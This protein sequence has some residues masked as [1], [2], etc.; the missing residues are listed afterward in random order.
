MS[1]SKEYKHISTTP[2]AYI[3]RVLTE[4]IQDVNSFSVI[5]DYVLEIKTGKTPSKSETKYFGKPGINWIKPTDIGKG[6]YL[7][8]STECVT[9]EALKDNVAT[10]Y[11]KNSLLIV[12]IGAGV[13]RVALAQSAVS[14]NQQITGILFNDLVLPEYAY[15]YFFCREDVIKSK[16]SKTTL[17]IIN[18]KGLQRLTFKC[19]DIRAQREFVKYLQYCESCLAHYKIPTDVS[20]AL[21]S[22]IFHI[23]ERVFNTYYSQ[24]ALL[25]E[26][27]SQLV[28]IQLLRQT[29]LQE[30]VQGKLVPQDP[31][32]EPATEL[33]KKIQ[34]EKEQLVKQGKIKKSKP[35]PP[36]SEDEI[37]YDLPKGWVWCRLEE[38]CTKIGSGSTPRGGKDVYKSSGVKFLRS[39]NIY[40][41]GLRLDNVAY[42]DNATQNKMQNTKVV[43][44]DILLNITGGSIGRCALVPND[45]DEANV[46]QHV[47]IIRP[48]KRLNNSYLHKLFL[49]PY[50]QD[51]IMEVQTGGNREGLA[52]KNMELM[53]IPLPS[54]KEQQRIV[55]K[56]EQL[57]QLC[58]ELEGQ[59]QQSKSDAEQLLQAVLREAFEGKD[60]PL[61]PFKGGSLETVSAVE[62]IAAEGEVAYKRRK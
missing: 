22:N 49:S 34:A 1:G 2:V 20:F 50:F 56:V 48:F 25:S 52:K 55:A 27:D 15:Y 19:P 33:L 16:A 31:N 44:D 7:T 29:I 5:G 4:S 24:K 54:F 18:Q 60:I 12:C 38:L 30:A 26:I 42:I 21:P 51:K 32:D 53:L 58:D 43:A 61:A 28:N 10:Q 37:P 57:M 35:L 17:P 6:K 23:S 13:G 41:E 62:G 8:E 11:E 14:S 59:V 36:V 45:F 40:N 47:T 46:S 9:I 39:Q 3:A